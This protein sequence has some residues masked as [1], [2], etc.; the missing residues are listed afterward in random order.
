LAL[1]DKPTPALIQEHRKYLG[2][3][4]SNTHA[5]WETIDTYYN[6]TFKL[7]PDGMDRPDWY[8]P[9][10]SRALVDHAV[11]HQLAFEPLVHRA[12]AGIG[13]E[14]K[15]RAD[16]LEP[17]L[18]AIMDEA[19][20]QEPNLTWKQ[21]GK[22]LLLYGYA[23]VEDG[24]DTTT[25]QAR[26]DKPKKGRS[27]LKEDFEGRMR[28]WEHRKKT[29]MPFR[30]RAVHPARVLLDPLKK[31]PR[32]A[33]KHTYR[34]SQDLAELTQARAEQRGRGRP[35]E[36]NPWEVKD[37]PFEMVLCDEWWSDCWHAL[38]TDAGDLLFVEKNTWGFVP[39]AHAFS[40]YGQE[41]TSISEI[42]PTHMAVGLLD[43][44]LE[45]LKAQAQA[46]AGRHN[47]LI[48]ATFNPM[49]TT[50]SADELQDQLSRSDIIEVA[51]RGE[52]GRMEMQQLPGW[53]FDTEQWMDKDIE[54]GTYSRSLAGIRDQGVSTVGQQAILSTSAMRKFVAPSKQLEHLAGRS[55]EHILQLIDVLDLDMYVRGY[56]V[57]STEIEHDY[58][59][60]VSFTL[61]DPVLQLQQREMGLREVQ[62]GVKSRETYWSAD[63]RLEDATGERKRLLED[64]VR[65]DPM[66]QK[67]LAQEVAREIGLLEL[68]E[69][70]RAKEEQDMQ[71]GAT[72][73]NVLEQSILGGDMAGGGGGM[74]GGGGGGMPPAAPGGGPQRDP[75]QPLTPDVARPSRVGQ[76]FAG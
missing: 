71:M 73:P 43:H 3:L 4:W 65:S 72:G 18:K 9:M 68:L 29:M 15:R 25:M 19:Q 60:R 38:A 44:A 46:V 75:R 54:L 36:V 69:K 16:Q 50:G 56:E 61:V 8:I 34:L 31:E 55:A 57:S 24:L 67:V 74:P 64:F 11:D 12:P 42:D 6:R 27:E 22:H 10:R 48:E 17:A 37:N 76:E 2:D 30:T 39:Y 45:S 66:V 13:E 53:M 52:V 40:G 35:V 1:E 23:V 26:R 70:Q 47:A 62:A 58:S 14:H 7:W 28:L 21:I 20:L 59:V 41:P 32:L 33:I 5:K 51:N 49:V 63:A